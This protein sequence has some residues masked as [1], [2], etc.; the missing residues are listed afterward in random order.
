MRREFTTRDQDNDQWTSG[1]CATKHLSGW[2]FGDCSQSEPF[3]NLNGVYVH[4]AEGGIRWSPM[5][6][7]NYWIK[8]TEM[9]L[10]PYYMFYA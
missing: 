3:L 1:N 8:S 6:G 4:S 10:R 9:K 5:L 2:W 7:D